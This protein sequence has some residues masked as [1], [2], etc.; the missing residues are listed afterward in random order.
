MSLAG[1]PSDVTLYLRR[2]FNNSCLG[3]CHAF[4][5]HRR[6]KILRFLHRVYSSKI[7]LIIDSTRT[8]IR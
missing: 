4:C 7:L 2:R 8:T 5:W 1:T 3:Q 6:W